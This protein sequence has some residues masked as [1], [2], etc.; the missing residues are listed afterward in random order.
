MDPTD[1]LPLKCRLPIPKEKFVASFARC[2]DR[3]KETSDG[4][5]GM[6]AYFRFLTL[7]GELLLAD[8][9][10]SRAQHSLSA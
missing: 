1:T 3:L 7:L 9:C 10:C 6:A 5:I 2:H 8:L 4:Q